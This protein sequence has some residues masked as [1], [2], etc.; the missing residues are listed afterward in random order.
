MNKS[1][2]DIV[3]DCDRFP[4]YHDNPTHYEAHMQGFHTFRVQGCDAL[5]GYMPNETAKQFSSFTNSDDFAKGYWHI[6]SAARTITLATAIDAAPEDRSRVVAY[7]LA[8]MK[9][10]RVFDVLCGWRNELYPVYGRDGKLLLEIE[11]SA[12]PLFGVVGYGILMTGYVKHGNDLRIWVPK[13]SKKKQTFPGM[14]DVTVGGGL[15]TK[16]NPFEC[17]IREAEEEASLLRKVIEAKATPV[18]NLSYIYVRDEK[19][20]GGTGL[21]QPEVEYIYDIELDE[22]TIP[23]P[24][25]SEVQGFHLLTVKEVQEALR[26]GKFKTNCGVVMVDFLIRHGVLKENTPGYL[27]ILSTRMHRQLE[28]PTVSHAVSS[29]ETP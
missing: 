27:D 12:C 6:D 23:R 11:R 25:D 9:K 26:K 2:L 24:N 8:K 14:Y 13:R 22:D 18:G 5:L 21:I 20:G 19:A 10:E 7:T 15:A 4:Y 1:L 16:E 28:F 29:L 3:N 17:A